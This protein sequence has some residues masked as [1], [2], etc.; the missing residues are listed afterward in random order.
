ME[1]LRKGILGTS[2]GL[3]LAGSSL[4]TGSNGAASAL[5]EGA[6]FVGVAPTRVLDTRGSTPLA[7][8]VARRVPLA[9][10]SGVVGV[11]VNLTITQA[12]ATD[13]PRCTPAAK[14]TSRPRQ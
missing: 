3:M 14:R 10:P 1:K 11:A 5:P 12:G 4:L 13:L 2:V 8:N 9:V 6:R 7:A